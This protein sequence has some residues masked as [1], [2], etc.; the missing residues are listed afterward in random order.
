MPPTRWPA[1]E[2]DVWIPSL[3]GGAAGRA[4]IPDPRRDRLP[5]SQARAVLAGRVGR[6]ARLSRPGGGSLSGR[7]AV[8]RAVRP[9]PGG[10]AAGGAVAFALGSPAAVSGL[11]GADVHGAPGASHGKPVERDRRLSALFAAVCWH[12]LLRTL[13]RPAARSESVA[14]ALGD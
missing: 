7:H 8:V 10:P 14:D 12:Q 3:W 1:P 9:D 6:S 4:G 2:R 5:R 11:A 13:R